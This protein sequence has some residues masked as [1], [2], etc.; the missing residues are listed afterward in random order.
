[1]QRLL[2]P[3]FGAIAALGAATFLVVLLTVRR[4]MSAQARV[5]RKR[6]G[7]VGL[8]VAFAAGAAFA[9]LA[10]PVEPAPGARPVPATPGSHA[11]GEDD[12]DSWR[13]FS[14]A[15]LPALSLD[16]PDGWKL[17][18]DKAARRLSASSDSARLSVSTAVLTE[19]VDVEAMLRQLADTQRTLGFEVGDTFTDHI[20]ALSATGFLATDPM[21]SICTWMIKRDTHLASSVICTAEGQVS[22]REA[23]RAPLATLRWR[24]PAPRGD[25]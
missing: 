5:L 8:F 25:R 13:R 11:D 22:A 10:V 1:L 14:S 19:A 16:A 7:A 9:L 3:L 12:V 18:F 6:V 17:A 21:R 24:A 4:P 15:K 23:C 20:G 2:P